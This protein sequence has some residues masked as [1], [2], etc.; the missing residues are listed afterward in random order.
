M[1]EVI[2][3]SPTDVQPVFDTIVAS[4]VSLCGA[5]M[6]AVYRFDGELLH[7]VA[8]HNYGPGVLEELR[9][10]HPRPPQA[11]QAS[12]RAILARAVVQL[13]DTLADPLYRHEIALAGDFRSI[14]AVPMLRNGAPIGVIVITRS[15]FGPFSNGH[16]ELLKTFTDQA[17][18]AIE[19]ARLFEAEQA[20]AKEL[21]EA[22]EF[23][24][25]SSEVLGVI[26]SAP[27]KVGPVFDTILESA[28]RLCGAEYGHLL[29]Y[30]GATWRPAALHNLPK[31][32]ADFWTRA[33]VVAGPETLLGRILA[34]GRPYQVADA[35][36][37]D[38]YRARTPLAI[39]TVEWGGARTLFG[40]PLL[41]DGKVIGAIVL[42]RKVV[43]AFNDKQIALLLSFAHQAVIAI[44][45]TR[46]FEAEQIRTKELQESLEYQTATSEVL[47]VISRSPNE[48]QPVLDS[49]VETAQRLCSSDRAQ[50]FKLQ[51]GKYHLAAHKGTN[52]EFLKFISENPI[53]LET[54]S[55]L[56]TAQA[57]RERCT[58]HVPDVAADPA[59]S[60]GDIPGFGRGRSV[61]AVPLMRRGEAVGVITVARDKVQPFTDRQISLVETF[62][63]QA[64]I[65]LNNVGLFEEVQA[66]TKEVTEALEYQKAITEVLSVISSSPNNLQPVLD[67]IVTTAGRL[68][69]ADYAHC[70]LERDGLYH[71]MA[72]HALDPDQ[73]REIPSRPVG[74]DRTSLTG[75]T[76]MEHR[77]IHVPDVLA[78][79][80]DTYAASV[81]NPARTMLGVPLL[82][83]GVAIGVIG[84]FRRAVKPFTQRQIDLVTTFADQAII[85]INN[86]RLF[87]EVQVK[88]KEVT[89]ALKYQIA[90]S[91]VLGV[92]SRSPNDL[93]PVLDTL[94]E[95]AAP[96]C[97]AS[98]ATLLLRDGDVVVP[99]AH[100]GPLLAPLG[101]RQPLNSWLG[102]GT[103]DTG[104][105]H[106]PLG[107]HLR[108]LRR[109]SGGQSDGTSVWPSGDLG[110]SFDA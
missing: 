47:G 62:A 51:A 94:V 6:G 87:E 89:E 11:D 55:G 109:V 4:A 107:R 15:E 50:F 9:R 81:G 57:A 26:S 41:K 77:T 106:H 70:R 49:I 43:R 53:S 5:R 58:V 98:T 44:E 38:G 68:C 8:H 18:I 24:T 45:N 90:T 64:V 2:S 78:D 14:L 60:K 29:L 13:E 21:S 80:E 101:D 63:N 52:P 75:R 65:A 108:G 82:R 16:I 93:Q 3:R 59:Y 66:R 17:V 54:D 76:I 10:T 22:L 91:D 37:G 46:L 35:L 20:R 1:L 105:T 32:Y 69:E 97:E 88:T 103:R 12:G 39:A 79:P 92:I 99:R 23:Q 67:A 7:L 30:D 61:L 110:Q 31:A 33:P 28:R 83:D 36:V 95:L 71:V 48:L 27:G 19:N 72:K 100:V 102:N 96:L 56:T 42:Y 84:L 85:A 25:A 86:T 74:A 73:I 40:V 34:T 104:R